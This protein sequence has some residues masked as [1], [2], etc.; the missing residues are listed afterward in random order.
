[1]RRSLLL[2]CAVIAGQSLMARP[3]AVRFDLPCR[4]EQGKY[5][6]M[7]E[8]PAGP[9]RFVF[10]TG[11]SRTT[12][13]ERLCRES[14]L[15]AEG[16]SLTGDFE[17]Y[18]EQ[19]ATARMPEL[20]M[21]ETVFKNRTVD[22]LPDSSYV[23]GLGVDGIVGSDLLQHFV[24]RFPAADSVISLAGD[25]RQFG[26]LDRK[27]SVRLH[28]E[29]GRPFIAFRV[30]D[31]RNRM[32]FYALFDS[33]ASDFF[34]CRYHECLELLGRGIL[35]NVRRASGHPGHMGWTNRSSLREAVRGTIPKIAIGDNMLSDI[36]LEETYGSTHKLG[37]GLLRRGEIVIDFPRRRFWL[38]PHAVQPDSDDV[39]VRNIS[40][41]IADGHLVVGQVWDETLADSV[42]PGDRIVRI[43]T[44]D[45]S[46]IDPCAVIRGEIHG[47]K[48]EMTVERR[49]GTRV[50]VPI[51]NL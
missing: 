48:P 30:G 42:S 44:L 49:D 37:C 6:V 15:V 20:R 32:K 41:A 34:S 35:R 25:Y 11:A 46:E 47:D 8:T 51:K 40:V 3:P 14:G 19:I 7:V 33:G 45:V 2:L 18:R 28:G 23:W 16:R 17:G 29:K 1:M 13:S 38:L 50:T 12:V 4:I 31:G 24:V 9:R 36:P 21:G 27:Q 43:G 26:D 5:I 22:V 39:A 10:D